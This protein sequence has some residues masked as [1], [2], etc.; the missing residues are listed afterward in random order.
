MTPVR[1]VET[2]PI[3]T[4]E[5]IEDITRRRL[6]TAMP[7]LTLV[8]LGMSCDDEPEET[9]TPEAPATRT[10]SDDTGR[11]VEVPRTPT[12]IIALSDSNSADQLLSLGASVVGTVTR[13]GSFEL[14]DQYDMSE[15]VSVGEVFEVDVEAIA[16][17][18]PDLIVG[19]AWEGKPSGYEEVAAALEAIAPTV[20][21]DFFKPVEA[22][23]TVVSD[24]VGAD[25]NLAVLQNAYND[26]VGVLPAQ[27]GERSAELTVSVVQFNDGIVDVFGKGWFPF[28]E[29]LDD[30]GV[31]RPAVQSSG[32]AFESCCASLSMERMREVDA[33]VVLYYVSGADHSETAVF[34]ELAATRAGQVY[35]WSDDWWGNTYRALNRVLDDLEGWLSEVDASVYS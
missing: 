25:E 12:R 14:A 15:I 16:A 4:L 10:F 8:A 11:T 20:W 27:L 13:G 17:L 28:G 3:R 1:L 32:E 23:M 22:V 21:L 29:V 34:G 18:D 6:L 31:S 9:P 5:P 7:I 2:A 26:R 30:L 19:P 35:E 24:L 33:D